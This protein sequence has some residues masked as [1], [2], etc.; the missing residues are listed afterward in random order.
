[1]DG[2]CKTHHLDDDTCPDHDWKSTSINMPEIPYG[3]WIEKLNAKLPD[4]DILQNPNVNLANLNN[5]K[6]FGF[7]M[8]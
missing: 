1:M 2:C 6:K 7:G 5:D 3:R 8:I 4:V